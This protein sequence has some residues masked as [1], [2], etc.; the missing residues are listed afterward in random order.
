MQD[1]VELERR[2]A[3]AL[4]RVARGVEGLGL[5]DPAEGAAAE[6]ARLTEALEE[7]RMVNAQLAERLRA[8][9][10]RDAAAPPTPPSS[11]KLDR[12]TRQHDVQGLELQRMRKTVIQLRETLRALREAAVAGLADPAQINRALLAEAEALRATRQTELALLD[13]IL[14]ELDPL[15]PP[16]VSESREDA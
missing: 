2:I 15:I 14:E 9:K 7:E 10:D 16:L 4:D 3:A 13:E 5:R 11:A 8:L 6:I 12:M 1:V